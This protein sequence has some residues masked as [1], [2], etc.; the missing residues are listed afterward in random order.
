MALFRCASG[1][2]GT[3]ITE[4][5]IWTNPNPDTSFASSNTNV[6]VSQNISNF[7]YIKVESKDNYAQDTATYK[8]D[9]YIKVSDWM[10]PYT[11][12]GTKTFGIYSYTN[13]AW[14]RQFNYNAETTITISACY[15]LNNASNNGNNA[16]PI[17]IKG[18]KVS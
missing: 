4:T 10:N 14:C 12:G 5:T 2:G 18:V 3:T 6:T 1:G 15:R 7:D 9:F 16:I 11:S 8:K 17:C 13:Y